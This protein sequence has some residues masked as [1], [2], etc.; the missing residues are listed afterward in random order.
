MSGLPTPKSLSELAEKLRDALSGETA[1]IEHV[2]KIM[3]AYSSNPD[4]WRMF[5]AFDKHKYT[6]TLVDTGNGKFN[7]L[8]LCWSEGQ[9]SSIHDHA[10][11]HCFMKMLQGHLKETRYEWPDKGQSDEMVSTGHIDLAKNEVTYISGKWMTAN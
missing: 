7:L 1:D 4:D 9:A 11:S 2:K 6:R 10:G 8:I 5:T 3:E